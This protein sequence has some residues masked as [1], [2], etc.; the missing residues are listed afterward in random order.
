MF[1]SD[2]Y[3]EIIDQFTLNGNDAS[4]GEYSTQIS[5]KSRNR[6]KFDVHMLGPMSKPMI[7]RISLSR[8]RVTN[9]TPILVWRIG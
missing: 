1:R 4:R 2:V 3:V 9:P 8:N 5:D 6:D 7:G